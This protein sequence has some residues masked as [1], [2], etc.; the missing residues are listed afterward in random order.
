MNI[1]DI[2]K[3]MRVKFKRFKVNSY[4]DKSSGSGAVERIDEKNG[5]SYVRVGFS[6]SSGFSSDRVQFSA[7]ELE[8]DE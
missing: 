3:G 8:N 5:W 7:E 6:T 4:G 2:K 1:S